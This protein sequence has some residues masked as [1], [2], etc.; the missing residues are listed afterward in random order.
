MNMNKELAIKKVSRVGVFA[1]LF[2]LAIKFIVGF[3][4]KSQ[5]LIADAINSAG[6]IFASCVSLI[7]IKVATKPKDA[8]HPY[9]HGKAEYIFS[10]LVGLSMI[11]AAFIRIKNSILSIINKDIIEVSIWIVIVCI[12][13][14]ITKFI[15]MIYA[16][17][18]Y[19][20]YNSILIKS[21]FE[22][23]RND[24]FVT[25]G[26]LISIVFSYFNIYYVDA[27]AGI[28]ISIWIICAGIKIIYSSSMVLMDTQ[29]DF[30][31]EAKC[32]ILKFSEV[33]N[34]DKFN[35][36]PVGD[37]Y[38]AIIEVA[39]KKDKSLEEVHEVLE[40]IEERLKSKFEMLHEVN[41]HVNPK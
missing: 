25:F 35:T 14:I 11:I 26:V 13:T 1:N 20:K 6:D 7:G 27:I 28:I 8:N 22:D 4:S 40:K 2:L 15:L 21:S 38:I 30:T 41:I 5:A 34:I 33:L 10:S 12:T 23:H 36:K 32:E 9:G 17:Y 37:S 31:Q 39:M 24:M 3:M 29:W 16:R 18:Y 19:K